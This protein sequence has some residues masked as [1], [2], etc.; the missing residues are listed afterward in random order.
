M[1]RVASIGGRSRLRRIADRVA[2]VVLSYGV[3]KTGIIIF[4]DLAPVW[5]FAGLIFVVPLLVASLIRTADSAVYRDRWERRAVI[6]LGVCPACAFELGVDRASRRRGVVCPECGGVWIRASTA[7]PA[8]AGVVP[9]LGG[10]D[11]RPTVIDRR[12]GRV[13]R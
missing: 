4:A 10:A 6:G 5:A 11:P 7:A 3:A 1:R 13:I 2:P 8:P 9:E 12:T